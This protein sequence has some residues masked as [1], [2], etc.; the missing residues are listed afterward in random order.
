MEVQQNV[1]LKN[2]NTFAVEAF[3]LYYAEINTIQDFYYIKNNSVFK[4]TPKLIL[5]QGSNILFTQNV[6]QLVLKINIKGINIIDETNDT[7]TVKCAAGELWHDF[8]M[9]AVTHNYGG[10]ENLSLI[11]GTIGACPIQN[12]GAYGSEVK[13]T[14][15]EVEAIHIETGEKQLFN[16]AQ[17]QF[18]Y[19]N[20][21]FKTELKNQYLI[22]YVTFKLHKNP[23]VNIAYK[24]L[25]HELQGE[26]TQN[27]TIQKVS[28]AVITVRNN[29]LPHW[30]Q[31][32]NA[33]SF[34]KNPIVTEA[35]FKK[36]QYQYP[37]IV[38]YSLPNTTDVKLA[39]AWLIETCGLKGFKNGHCGVHQNQPLVLVNL[40]NANGKELFE[41]SHFLI[42]KVENTFGVMLERE[43]NIL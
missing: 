43:V 9:W 15:Y 14:I 29:K 11:P 6:N 1:S 41:F 20:S 35:Q 28:Q 31:L 40:G 3:A 27:L 22:T 4:S 19:R 18:D 8:V 21:V 32:G 23:K 13:N 17:C 39:A 30:K 7:I 42:Q 34:F 36:L 2:I 38:F 10:V 24:D 25:L 33:G 12:I 16:N 26:D 37:N 5:G